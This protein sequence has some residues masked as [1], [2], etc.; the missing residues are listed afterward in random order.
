MK[1]FMVVSSTVEDRDRAQSANMFS[2]TSAMV[3]AAL[4]HMLF[5]EFGHDGIYIA[6]FQ[7]DLYSGISCVSASY[8]FHFP[9]T[10]L[11][12]I[13]LGPM[14]FALAGNILNLIFRHFIKNLAEDGHS[15]QNLCIF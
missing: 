6:G 8:S 10:R 15:S 7:M 9:F 12:K 11:K 14:I 5:S 13:N 3:V 2:Y 1:N 4:T